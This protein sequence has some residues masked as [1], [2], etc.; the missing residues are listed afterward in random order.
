MTGFGGAQGG[1]GGTAGSAP[2]TGTAG[3]GGAGAC[4][5]QPPPSFT[6]NYVTD[7]GFEN[8]GASGWG[9]SGV[10]G[11][12]VTTSAFHCGARSGKRTAR[13]Y[14][15]DGF[16]YGGLQSLQGPYK[17][18]LWVMQNGGSNLPI[19]V[20]SLGLCGDSTMGFGGVN[21][22]I[23]PNQWTRLAGM[24]MVGAGCMISNFVVRQASGTQLPDLFIDDVYVVQ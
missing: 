8:G 5:P 12:E 6:T 18:S 24:G 21:Q 17:F 14:A 10:N 13:N 9:I 16:G 23:A 20:D 1:R 15:T 7:P 11:F 2:A 22:T 3:A 4:D 19:S